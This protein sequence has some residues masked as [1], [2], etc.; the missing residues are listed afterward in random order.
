MLKKQIYFENPEIV[1]NNAI[2]DELESF[3]SSIASET[4][5]VVSLRQGT[6]A[7]KLAYQIIANF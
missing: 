5:P 3:A 2:L 4:T 7:L 1:Q 6:E